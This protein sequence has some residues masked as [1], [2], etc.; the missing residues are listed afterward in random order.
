MLA[1]S[2]VKRGSREGLRDCPVWE[3][4]CYEE[5]VVACR[6]DAWTTMT[7]P[8]V[9]RRLPLRWA[10]R[11]LT[12]VWGRVESAIAESGSPVLNAFENSVAI[13]IV[14]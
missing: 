8:W 11:R 12:V 14:G 10:E 13:E 4:L 5:D 2:C 3:R 7:G 6:G 1:D 9:G